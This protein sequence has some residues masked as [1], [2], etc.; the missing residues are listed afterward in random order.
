[1]F[2]RDTLRA[3]ALAS[4]LGFAI[5]I[6]LLFFGG[7]G[8]WLGQQL[9]TGPWLGLVGLLIGLVA[10]GYTIYELAIAIPARRGK[11]ATAARKTEPDREDGGQ[12]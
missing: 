5:A 7:G 6:P 12:D 1:M 9:H 3:L 11:S 4:Q 2:D 8:F 10:S